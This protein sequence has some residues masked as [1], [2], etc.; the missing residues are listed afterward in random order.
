MYQF[1]T[2]P[3]RIIF[4]AIVSLL[5]ECRPLMLHAQTDANISFA[6]KKEGSGRP[7]ILI[8]GFDCSGE[9]WKDVVKH[10]SGHYTCYSLTLP[11]FAG[12]PPITGD[13]IFPAIMQQLAGYIRQEK[14]ERPIIVGHSMGGS[15]ALDFAIHYPDLAGDLII[16]SSAPCLPALKGSEVNADSLANMGQMAKKYMSSQT[17]EQVLQSRPYI[18]TMM[19][20]SSRLP[21]IMDMTVKSDR[22]AGGEMVCE[23]LSN[24]LRP[25]T[26]RIQSRI[27]ALADWIS[28][29]NY[30][31]THESTYTRLKDQYKKAAHVTIAINDKAHHFIM[32]DEPAWFYN[33]IDHFLAAK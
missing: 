24:D 32:F 12:Q 17:M 1:L 6:V 23:M 19:L 29:K 26:D 8:P 9:V 27:L 14:L 20:D 15:L 21:E 30:G 16:V 2:N 5:L 3:I 22:P 10:Y 33:Q 31:A 11:G 18:A 25:F 4:I 28:Y 13:S 7:I